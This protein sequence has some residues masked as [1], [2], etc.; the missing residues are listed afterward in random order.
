MKGQPESEARDGSKVLGRERLRPQRS[1]LMGE[2]QAR[3][4]APLGGRT[5]TPAF[6]PFRCRTYNYG[7][8]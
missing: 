5:R 6:R 2:R 1:W 4:F 7:F 8:S 3:T